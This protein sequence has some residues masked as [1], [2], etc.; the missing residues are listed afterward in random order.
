MATSAGAGLRATP[1]KAHRHTPGT[2]PGANGGEALDTN[3]DDTV[4]ADRANRLEANP[5]AAPR[6]AGR[7]VVIGSG[8]AG[9]TAA[10][11]LGDCTLV[12]KT[13]LGAG[14]SR[15][16]QGGIAAALGLDDTP[17]LHATDTVAVGGGL[18][19]PHVAGVV[20]DAAVERIEWLTHLGARFDAGDNGPI[21]LGREAGHG[22]RRIVHADGDAT[23][24]EVMRTLVAAV[25]NRPDIVVRERT[26]AIDLVRRG[27]RVAGV[28]VR[29]I[30]HANGA[31]SHDNTIEVLTA[32]AVVLATG[33]I[34]R[35]YAHT[36]N[37]AE[38]T[39]DGL[40]M[41]LRA[42]AQV[43][44][45]EFVQ[46]HPTALASTLDP[47][48]LLTE[49]L[50]GEGAQL[51]GASGRR[52]LVDVHP[53]AEL[54][55]RDVV[56]RANWHEQQSGPIY[57][58]VRMIDRLAER[59]PTV[60]RYAVQAGLAPT[61]QP[62]PVSP[63]QHYHMGGVA[64]DDAGRTSLDGLYA[65]GEVA[66]TGLHG[67]NRLASNSL[68]EGLVLGRRVAHAITTASV[69]VASGDLTVPTSALGLLTAAR[70][71]PDAAALAAL[72]KLMWL[73]GGLV[74][75]EAGLTSALKD[76]PDLAM[77]LARTV[78]GRN[79]VDVAEVVLRAA[80]AR[81]ESRGSHYRRD[82]PAPGATHG[83]HTVL[84]LPEPTTT[85]EM[86][87]VAVAP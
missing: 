48:P 3:R 22:Q 34:G 2:T 31:A 26:A 65:C 74:R 44:D 83:E 66:A 68:I 37:P 18:S 84:V 46:F 40:A 55:P 42:G 62:L 52:Y 23:G 41:A 13:A 47:M 14:A 30:D 15:L 78:E 50:R 33:G 8:I 67:A 53:D 7:A 59:F 71:L 11:E 81:E 56:A 72:R 51:V 80:L 24:A 87:N 64:T 57:L 85:L 28:A 1:R 60:H 4:A 5:E 25:A 54:A 63:A 35:L 82:Y 58:D 45:P 75:E 12:T 9:L 73:Q 39:G 29:D 21:A 36:T 38:A 79:L 20:A 16:A 76:L 86:A 69:I 32:D 17:S 61:R 70:E 27:N 43:Q 19:N 6:N 10:L 49:A 77:A